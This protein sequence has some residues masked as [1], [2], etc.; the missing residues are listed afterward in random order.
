MYLRV[1]FVENAPL[2][3]A[4]DLDVGIMNSIIYDN[5]TSNSIIL[6]GDTYFGI[7]VVECTSQ[8]N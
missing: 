6:M 5:D 8:H 1:P 7:P 3:L 2:H 4:Y